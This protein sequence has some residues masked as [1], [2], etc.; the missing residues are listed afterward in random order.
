[1]S[2][3]IVLCS[4]SP[5]AVEPDR[6]RQLTTGLL[7]ALLVAAVLNLASLLMP[8]SLAAADIRTDEDLH[9]ALAARLT[10]FFSGLTGSVA[11]GRS[12]TRSLGYG[13]ETFDMLR[14]GEWSNDDLDANESGIMSVAAR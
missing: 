9:A 10:T 1:M 13:K 12:V 6:L 5:W 8:S 7:A 3:H 2:S 14:G 4:R 11:V